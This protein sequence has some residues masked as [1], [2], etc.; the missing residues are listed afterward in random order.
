MEHLG[1]LSAPALV[2][3]GL[4]VATIGVPTQFVPH[5]DPKQILARFGMDGPGIAATA[6]RA[7]DDVTG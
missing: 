3:L 5:G 1:A 2:Y 4:G 6:R 7:L